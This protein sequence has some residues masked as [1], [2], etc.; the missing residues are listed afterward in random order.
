ME[1]NLNKIEIKDTNI[2]NEKRLNANGN[3]NLKRMKKFI[4]NAENEICKIKILNGYGSGFFCKIPY[5]DDE[6]LLKILITNNHVLN[7][8]YLKRENE[9]KL[10]I[11]GELKI[12][13][14]IDERKIW[15]NKK[16]DYTIIEILKKDNINFFL[17][18]DEYINQNNYINENYKNESIIIPAFMSNEEIEYDKGKIIFVQKNDYKFLA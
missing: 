1:N 8:E 16:I 2:E 11:D 9:I 4:M 13:S 15:T 17:V 12:L 14:L 7:E 6:H 3:I 10:E 5:P 18:L